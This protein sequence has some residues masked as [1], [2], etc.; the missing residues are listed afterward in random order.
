MKDLVKLKEYDGDD[1]VVDSFEIEKELEDESD[2]KVVNSNIPTLDKHIDGFQQGELIVVGGPR[3]S[4]KTLLCQTL[5]YDLN[6]Q[7][8]VPLWIQFENQPKAFYKTFKTIG[9]PFFLQPRKLRTHSVDWLEERVAEAIAKFRAGA[10]FI[11]HLHFL[12]DIARSRSPSIEIGQVIRK[13][14]LIAVDY[15]IIIFILCH[16]R[17]IN[18]NKDP[19]DGDFRDSSL[20]ASESDTGLLIWRTPDVENEAMLKVCY[21]R[22]TGANEQKVR[23]IKIEG[24]LREVVDDKGHQKTG[25]EI[26]SPLAMGDQ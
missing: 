9:L 19:T 20:I 15:N 18:P 8:V 1:R 24:F 16:L 3:K 5:T 25:E 22:R 7:N 11:D 21:S 26:W 4:G 17:K 10:V 14:K 12:F 2:A 23:M 6:K 13:L